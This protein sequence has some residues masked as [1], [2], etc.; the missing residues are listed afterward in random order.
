MAS[1]AHSQ[2]QT[3]D[4]GKFE[5]AR[6]VRGIRASHDRRGMPIKRQIED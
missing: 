3:L 6:D 5:G 1:S 2:W 4:P